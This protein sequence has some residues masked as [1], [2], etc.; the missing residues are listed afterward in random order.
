MT[1]VP[2][3]VVYKPR[4]LKHG[5]LGRPIIGYQVAC[6]DFHTIILDTNGT[7][8][9]CGKND[10]GQCGHGTPHNYVSP[11]I[12]ESLNGSEISMVAAGGNVSMALLA[13]G[14]IYT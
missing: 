7:V 5:S 4:I 14:S 13:D 12:V 11:R 2:K 10:D 3:S 1:K 6:G 9:T 8:Y